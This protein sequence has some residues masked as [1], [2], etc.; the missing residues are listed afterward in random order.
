MLTQCFISSFVNVPTDASCRCVY[1]HCC[2]TCTYFSHSHL[3]CQWGGFEIMT[4]SWYLEN[5]RGPS[6]GCSLYNFLS[7]SR[8]IN[9]PITVSH[10]YGAIMGF[11]NHY[12]QTC[13]MKSVLINHKKRGRSHFFSGARIEKT[14]ILSKNRKREKV[15]K[16]ANESTALIMQIC[17]IWTVITTDKA[18]QGVM[19]DVS[20][21]L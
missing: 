1:T 15:Q 19:T 6:R 13:S 7:F 4:T 18:P 3:I 20:L 10:P 5:T 8:H 17:F 9:M 14:L 21:W 16:T 2:G 12:N 11:Q